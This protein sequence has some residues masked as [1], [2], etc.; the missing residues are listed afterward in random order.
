M[1]EQAGLRP[2]MT[3]AE[4]GVLRECYSKASSLVEF[5]C[6]GS[7]LLA[8]QSARLQQVWSVESDPGWV[9]DLRARPD[10]RHAES[11]GRLHLLAADIGPTGDFGMPAGEGSSALWPGYYEQVWK[12]PA[13]HSADLVLIDGRFRVSCALEAIVQCRPHTILL[14][15]DF[16]NRPVYHP[17]L[18][19][20][21]WLGSCD[22][23]AIL[24][25]K[26]VLDVE[27]LDAV[28][29]AHRFNPD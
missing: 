25:R 28:R 14:F 2:Q 10:I 23:L 9:A 11:V 15:H 7:T 13:T 3:D 19:F 8:L 26:Q 6:G 29:A 1:V 16:W 24:R 17:V 20:T 4:I 27:K 21:D 12:D 22:S 5:G 18:A